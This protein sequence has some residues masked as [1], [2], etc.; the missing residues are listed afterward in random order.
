MTNL[1]FITANRASRI[2]K[3]K[4]YDFIIDRILDNKIVIIEEVFDP[5]EKMD[6]IA[7]GLERINSKK[8][9]GI[10]MLEIRVKGENSGFLRGKQKDLQFNL[11]APGSSVI[12]QE[13]DGHYSVKMEEG[14]IVSALL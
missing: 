9:H 2:I 6:L 3:P 5:S 11:F 4:L 14:A 1:E 13:E 12:Q 10:K 8:Y 7:R